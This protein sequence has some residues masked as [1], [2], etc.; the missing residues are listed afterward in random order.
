MLLQWGPISGASRGCHLHSPAAGE[1]ARQLPL[2][3]LLCLLRLRQ[4]RGP[5]APMCGLGLSRLINASPGSH[6]AGNKPCYLPHMRSHSNAVNWSCA[7]RVLL[8]Q[9]HR[10]TRRQRLEEEDISPPVGT[11]AHRLKPDSDWKL[12][13]PLWFLKDSAFEWEKF[14]V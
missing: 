2:L 3:L 11:C 10:C 9:A 13:K 8:G 1:P 14:L 12:A 7:T 4:G 6:M 5:T